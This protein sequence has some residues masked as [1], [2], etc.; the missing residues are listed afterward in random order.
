MTDIR[1]DTSQL[2]QLAYVLKRTEPAIGKELGKSFGDI[3]QRVAAR[4]RANASFSSRIPGS[5]KV[6][7]RGLGVKVQAGSGNA[8]HAAPFEHGGKP[9]L[10]RHPVFRTEINPKT[11]ADQEAHP[12]LA[13]AADEEQPFMETAALTA[14]DRALREAG[15]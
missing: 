4:A 9:G 15:F 6:R 5:I 14:V 3:G 12:F 2:K 1:I 8:P 7:R 13:P 10:F 11:W